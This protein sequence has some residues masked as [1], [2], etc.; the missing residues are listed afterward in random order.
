MFNKQVSTL[1]VALIL[2]A[3]FASA[4]MKIVV[5]DPVRAILESDEAKV[6]AD[7]ANAEMQPEQDELRAAA[8]EMQAL[9]AKLQK[10]GEVM[11][12]SERRKA[13]NDLES[14]QADI[15]FGSQ[16]LQKQVQDK[17]QEILQAMAPKYE[18]VLG[19]LIQIDQIDLILSPNQVQY[20]NAKHDISR[21]VT[22]K[23]NE[24]AE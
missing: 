13:I 22:E 15:Q 7:A 9:Q 5:L 18:K 17:R 10:D 12:E 23:L 2:A 20:A 24:E 14:M 16:K 1:L 4:E 19:D 6:L 21:R 8:E 3:P 11:S